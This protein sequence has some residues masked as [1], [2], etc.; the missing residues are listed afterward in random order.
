[1]RLLSGRADVPESFAPDGV[2]LALTRTT[3]TK[4]NEEGRAPNTSAVW[5]M[6]PDGSHAQRLARR[7]VDPAFS[8]DGRR[9]AFA[10]DRDENGELSYGDRV[11]VANELYVMNAHGSHQRRLT[12]T[13]D[14]TRCSPRGWRMACGS[15]ANG[16]RGS[17]PATKKVVVRVLGAP[18]RKPA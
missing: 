11:L 8:P 3:V 5:V 1:M 6:R 12:R 14:L 2:T 9:I 15:P 13:T 17:L 4:L 16:A 10:S 7:S 18:P